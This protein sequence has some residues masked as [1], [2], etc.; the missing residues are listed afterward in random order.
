MKKAL[1]QVNRN[2]FEDISLSLWDVH[3]APHVELRVYRRAARPGADTLPRTEGIS[4]PVDVLPDLLRMLEQTQERLIR[5]G[6][7]HLQSSAAVTTTMEGGEMVPLGISVPRSRRGDCRRESRT[8]LEVPAGCRLLDAT[9]SHPSEPLIG[10]IKD[11][12]Q[13]GAQLWLPR[14]LPLYSRV[15]VF[16]QI[17]G[18][19]F[20]GRAQVVGAE[21][22]PKNGRYRHGL[23]W[24]N[25]NPEAKVVLSKILLPV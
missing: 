18:L 20:Q 7:V 10:E 13:G 1:D 5:Q 15:E 21:V 8:A 16:M 25:L 17:G 9:D 23:R 11:V 12:S 6:L 22:H 24:L 19:N 4:V 14:R 3:G 2:Q